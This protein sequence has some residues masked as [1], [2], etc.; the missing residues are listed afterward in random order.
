MKKEVNFVNV[1][2]LFL[3]SSWTV[4]NGGLIGVVG[5]ECQ[6]NN[7]FPIDAEARG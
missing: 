6:N 4:K 1:I 7:I 5:S 3:S 2:L